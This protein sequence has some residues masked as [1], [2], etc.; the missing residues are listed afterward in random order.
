MPFLAMGFAVTASAQ[1][2][3]PNGWHLT[4]PAAN[5]YN[6]I[7]LGKAYEFLKGKK[8]NTVVVAVIDSGIDTLHED[9]GPVL[10]TNPKEI[11]GN[12][13]DDDKNGYV[14]DVH[15]WNFLGGKDGRNV[16][17]DS[18]ESARV[19]HRY[20]AKFAGVT[21]PS[22][23]S[24]DDRMLY[25]MWKRSAAETQ[26][27]NPTDALQLMMLG[28]AYRAAQGADTTLQRELGKKEFT[29]TEVQAAT[30]ATEAGKS[31]K[32]K[33]MLLYQALGLEMSRSNKEVLTE[34]GEYVE[35]EERKAAAKDEAP[36]AY[37]GEVVKDNEGDIN[38]R[39]YGNND[40]MASTATHGTHVSGIIA[41]ARGNGKGVDGVA[42]N[43]R[44]MTLRAV[45]DGDEH[46]KDI[47][48]AIRYAADNGAKVIN[49][50]FGK[51]FS[52]EKKWVDDAVKYAQSKG[53]LL[54]HAAGND[55]ANIDTAWNFPTS[56]AT[57]GTRATNWITVGASAAPKNGL[58]ASFSNWGKKEVDVFAPG[59]NIYS[60]VPG[61]NTYRNL[62]G[63][64]MASPVVAG[65]A[66][67]ILE[68]YPK[69]SPEQV[70]AVIEQ[71]AMPFVGDVTQ[72]GGGT[73][74]KLSELSR[75]GGVVNA[76]AA[77]VM[78]DELSRTGKFKTA[79]QKVKTEGSDVKIKTKTPD[80]KTKTKVKSA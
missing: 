61:G 8:S 4:D 42:D 24:G 70:K 72:P 25:D 77:V 12:G 10:W 73:Q 76:H 6:G 32:K 60:S 54:V 28:N 66:A 33:F 1:R 3:A 17:A 27:G 30:L 68:Y 22:T 55:G 7:S 21:N 52:P 80:T 67:L 23:L 37:R 29:A 79:S 31:A 45:P 58:V 56:V 41:A 59:H 16:G 34:I 51:G 48:L 36:R 46:D 62:S 14:D 50:S 43:V 44:I 39:N 65:L 5:G 74:T 75:T 9:L 35:G 49:M 19:Y 13:V 38:D 2:E 64:S 71:S 69:L 18:Y 40:I 63:T 11:P 26:G 78:A 53:V 15:G 47:A 20:K 57:T